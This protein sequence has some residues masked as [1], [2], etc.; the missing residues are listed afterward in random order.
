MLDTIG[1]RHTVADIYDKYNLARKY[2]FAINMDLIAGL[3]GETY[4]MFRHSV[5]CAV[6]CGADNITVHTLALKHGSALKEQNFAQGQSP[7]AKMVEFAHAALYAAGYIP[8]YMYRQKY[9]SDNL[10]NV[11]FTKPDK[12][13]LYN[14]DIMEE[15][16][17]IIACGTNAI[18]KRISVE[19]NRIERAANPKDV[20]TYIERLDDFL[21]KKFE[22]FS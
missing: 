21:Q 14:I 15:I 9:M 10:E 13:C 11:G 18:S 19:Q 17:D 1:R 6:A 8:Y 2:D 4:E 12:P 3:P 16:S 7:V 20:I 22:L 5:E